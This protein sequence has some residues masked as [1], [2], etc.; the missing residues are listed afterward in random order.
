MSNT[1]PLSISADSSFLDQLNYFIQLIKTKNGGGLLQMMIDVPKYKERC[2]RAIVEHCTVAD[3]NDML[4]SIDDINY[5]LVIEQI[6]FFRKKDSDFLLD[7]A[8][9]ID[10][11][12]SWERDTIMDAYEQQILKGG[13]LHVVT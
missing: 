11:L 4:A 2:Q 6:I 10:A 3:I 12:Q 7:A 9:N 5:T 1:V 13:Q 8:K